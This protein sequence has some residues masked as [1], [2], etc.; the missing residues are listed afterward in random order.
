MRRGSRTLRR[1]IGSRARTS[2][3]ARRPLACKWRSRARVTM[4]HAA[5][6]QRDPC[7]PAAPARGLRV[8]GC[9]LSLS[10][11]LSLTAR[12][13]C[14]A[15]LL[16]RRY[17]HAAVTQRTKELEWFLV[18]VGS[19]PAAAHGAVHHS[20]SSGGGGSSGGSSGGCGSSGGSSGSG[21][22]GSSGGSSGG[23][24]RSGS[25]GSRETLRDR[26]LAGQVRR[27]DWSTHGHLSAP[28]SEPRTLAFP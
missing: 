28:R 13:A 17:D 11:S 24:R 23:L 15:W 27:R 6:H 2:G 10:L 4:A 20:A 8:G 3:G 22:G 21:G 9:W 26:G 12:G 18:R 1:R 5:R 16:L 25:F 14:V 7:V 19:S